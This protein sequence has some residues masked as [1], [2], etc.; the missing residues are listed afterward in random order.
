MTVNA[1]A[2][3]DTGSIRNLL[4]DLDNLL[5]DAFH[6][7]FAAT[8]DDEFDDALIDMRFLDRLINIGHRA[9]LI[10]D[11]AAIRPTQEEQS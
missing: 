9:C 6:A 10:R 11:A 7:K 5:S 4:R 8:T 2:D 1:K 3:I